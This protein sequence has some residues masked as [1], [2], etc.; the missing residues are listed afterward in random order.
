MCFDDFSPLTPS[1]LTPS[2]PHTLTPSSA[3][4]QS[5]DESEEDIAQTL[6][7]DFSRA[8][9]I[10]DRLVP[11]AVLFYT[12]EALEEDEDQVIRQGGSCDLGARSCDQ[13]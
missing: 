4:A 3:E 1:P 12:G 11:K 8:E 10:R 7:D 9:F 2:H 6:S 13:A 5:P